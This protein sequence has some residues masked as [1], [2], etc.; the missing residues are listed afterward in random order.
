MDFLK[1]VPGD[2]PIVV[3][4]YFPASPE[5][6]FSAWTDP[7]AVMKWFGHGLNS[8]HSA[9]IDLRPGGA[10]RFVRTKDAEKSVGFEGEYQEIAPGEKLVFSW[11]HVVVQ[12]DGAREATPYSRVEVTFTPTGKGTTVRVVHSAVRSEDARRGIGG[13]WQSAFTCLAEILAS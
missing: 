7:E 1:S 10:W 8:L 2:D 5:R 3:E 9:T 12:A 4:G 11:A 6:V 13:G